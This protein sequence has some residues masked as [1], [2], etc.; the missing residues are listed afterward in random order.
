MEGG[1]QRTIE[2]VA[3][4]R[5]ESQFVSLVFRHKAHSL[6]FQQTGQRWARGSCQFICQS[7][8]RLYR[9]VYQPPTTK[10]VTHGPGHIVM[11]GN[12]YH[13]G[14]GV[15]RL[16]LLHRPCQFREGFRPGNDSCYE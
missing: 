3:S 9:N 1:R 10:P 11:V 4:G 16:S 12:D 8:A 7:P 6:G 2:A 5:V 14:E 13:P 15:F